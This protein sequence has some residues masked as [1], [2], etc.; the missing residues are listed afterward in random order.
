MCPVLYFLNI[1]II[2]R[3]IRNYYEGRP[4]SN[5]RLRIQSARLFCCSRSLVSGVQCDI[6]NCLVQLYVVPCHVVNAEIA[7]AMTVSIENS[8]DCEVRGVVR[9]LQA[10]EILGYLA[11]EA[12]SRVELFRC[13]TMHVRTL[14]GRR[15]PCCVR[16][17]IG[18]YSSILRRVRTRHRRTSSCFQK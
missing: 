1:I 2:R 8:D 6:E 11:E 5:E 10:D 7:V 3:I 13:T 16:N 17:T 9:L 12:S 4:E 15:K 14:P 18:T